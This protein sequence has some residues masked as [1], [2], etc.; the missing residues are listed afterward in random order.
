MGPRRDRPAWELFLIRILVRPP[1]PPVPCFIF[2]A[3]ENR[4]RPYVR[5]LD[6]SFISLL[7]LL[8][9]FLSKDQDELGPSMY[10]IR[11]EEKF[12]N[13]AKPSP[14][15]YR[16]IRDRSFRAKG[17]AVYN[18]NLCH[19]YIY[20][21]LYPRKLST[22]IETLGY[23]TPPRIPSPIAFFLPAYSPSSSSFPSFD[24]IKIYRSVG[25]ERER[26]V[27]IRMRG[28][29]RLY[30]SLGIDRIVRG[31]VIFLRKLLFASYDGRGLIIVSDD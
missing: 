20:D 21:P 10:G 6:E 26:T 2:R 12:G 16:T 8:F 11:F 9:F 13:V 1:L 7:F 29:K 30:F 27:I 15:R 14:L 31:K 5:S 3:D 17:V 28:K 23:Y 19:N 4:T 18:H 22:K 24:L 25:S